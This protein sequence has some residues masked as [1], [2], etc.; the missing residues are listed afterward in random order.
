MRS[1]YGIGRLRVLVQI[2]HVRMRRRRVEVEVVFLDVLAVVPL[3]VGQP[4]EPLLEDRVL[5]VPQ[6]EREAEE[7]PVVGN[8][9]QPVLAPADR[10]ASGPD[11][12]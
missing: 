9:R 10:L 2:L 11:H 7:L 5:T 4:E 6:G 12:G 1:L 8:A 3:A